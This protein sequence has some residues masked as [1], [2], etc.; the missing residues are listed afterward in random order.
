MKK[1]I[2]LSIVISIIMIGIGL[3]FQRW[4][5]HKVYGDM[6][7]ETLEDRM[8]AMNYYAKKLQENQGKEKQIN[9]INFFRVFPS[10]F[11]TFFKLF[12]RVYDDTIYFD[13][14]GS[15]Y[16]FSHNPW[17]D[18][19]PIEKVVPTKEDIPKEPPAKLNFP[20]FKVWCYNNENDILDEVQPYIQEEI[21]YK[22]MISVGMGGFWDSDS[23]T[24]LIWHITGL[25]F[26]NTKLATKI[27]SSYTDDEIASF[28]F[29]LFDGPAP[30]HPDKVK[31]KNELYDK[32][33]KI[34]PR[35][36]KQIE[37]AYEAVL[38]RF[39]EGCGHEF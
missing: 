10:D 39:S 32:I 29:F 25:M 27:L 2:K 24:F 38:A 22:K 16:I 9:C 23:V 12:H 5:K 21:Y 28:W 36:A 26:Q 4:Y 34:N 14:I 31:W 13:R 3:V 6:K 1:S 35:V 15:S 20:D 11:R 18:F 19:H 37:R 17:G 7:I 33:Q 8:R 30:S